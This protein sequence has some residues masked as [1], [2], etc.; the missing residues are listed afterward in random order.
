MHNF[1]TNFDKILD[2]TKSLFQGSLNAD[3]NWKNR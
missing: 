2:I 1:K 3:G